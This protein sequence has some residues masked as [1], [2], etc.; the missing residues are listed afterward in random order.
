[1]SSTLFYTE[2]QT[3]K[4]SASEALGRPKI[5][6]KMPSD[7]YIVITDIKKSTHAVNMGMSELINLI[8]TGSIIAA[9]NIAA[10]SKIDIPFFFGGDGATLLIPPTLLD[11]TMDAL[12][13]YQQNVKSKFDTGLRV[14]NFK[15][16]KV[17]EAEN[18]LKIA[19]IKLN[20]LF[21]IPIVLG[22]GLHFAENF[23][24]ANY[25]DVKIKTNDKAEL[26]LEGMEC[27]WNQIPPPNTSDEVLCL[28]IDALDET[29]QAQVFKEVLD[30]IDTIYGSHQKRNP[31]SVPK[32]KLSIGLKKMRTELR[33]RKLK[34]KLIDYTKEWL[35]TLF[36][37]TW[38]LASK[39]GQEYLAEL[40]QLSD[41]F[42]L[43]GRIN[44]VISGSSQKR[45]LLLD[46]LEKE[47][48]EG[49]L[50]FG[51]HISNVSIISCYVRDRKANHIHF[52][53]GGKGGYTKAAGVL[54]SKISK[55][56]VKSKPI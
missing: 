28:L 42:V 47:E 53:D 29:Q 4:I 38:F 11:R 54:K 44:M 32:L 24:K 45:E 51:S 49:K 16:A 30:T 6:T 36:G 18:N 1:M 39:T 43:D 8:A 37:K 31:I 12:T 21:A 52:I 50:I 15:V 48:K 25:S 10:E 40:V 33:M 56:I 23:I 27:R 34:P 22:N 55:N 41:I 14:A 19:K 9:L 2:L 7:W 5:F 17:Y 3:Y 20:E 26:R 46:Y 13:L 35:I